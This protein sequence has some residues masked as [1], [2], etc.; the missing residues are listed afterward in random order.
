MFN[1][2]ATAKL[3]QLECEGGVTNAGSPKP[4][5][6]GTEEGVALVAEVK[7]VTWKVGSL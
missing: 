6:C 7:N 3:P 2:V 1:G 5:R 4:T